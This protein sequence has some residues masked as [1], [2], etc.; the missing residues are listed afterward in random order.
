[1]GGPRQSTCS[2]RVALLQSESGTMTR[3]LH[4]RFLR[5]TDDEAWDLATGSRVR[6][7][8][9][10]R[11]DDACISDPRYGVCVD[12]GATPDGGYFEAWETLKGGPTEP[13]HTQVAALLEAFDQG[14]DGEPRHVKL[15]AT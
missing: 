15:H 11:V 5:I 10:I 1:M 12:W 8:Y 6:L 14:A 3:L 9:A 7:R 4:D 13:S 2:A